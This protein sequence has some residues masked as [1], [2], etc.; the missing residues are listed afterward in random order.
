MMVVASTGSKLPRGLRGVEHAAGSNNNQ[1]YRRF[2]H[3]SYLALAFVN[4]QSPHADPLAPA[5]GRHALNVVA[6]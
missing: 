3:L 1:R 2:T 6:R 5:G 4:H